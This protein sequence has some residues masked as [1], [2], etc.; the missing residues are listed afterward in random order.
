MR[1]HTPSPIEKMEEIENN[2]DPQYQQPFFFYYPMF[3][4]YP[5]PSDDHDQVPTEE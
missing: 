3:S 5:F 2:F 4:P 1:S